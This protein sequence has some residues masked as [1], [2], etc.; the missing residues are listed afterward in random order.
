MNKFFQSWYL[1]FSASL[2]FFAASSAATTKNDH[3]FIPAEFN[4]QQLSNSG[5]YSKVEQR[6]TVQLDQRYH[7]ADSLF[8]ATK[9]GFKLNEDAVK[10]IH[11]DF[12]PTP[13]KYSKL[14]TAPIEKPWMDFQ[15][16]LSVPKSMI[17]TTK[18]R[19]PENYIRMLPYSIW[20]RFGIDPIYDMYVFGS[21]KQFEIM[22][23]LNLERAGE[24]SRELLPNAGK[25]NPN[26]T[27]AS[28]VI[29]NLDFIGFLYNNLNKQGR[30]R[31]HNRKHANAWKTY[32]SITPSSTLA[33]T[34]AMNGNKQRSYADNQSH[35]TPLRQY[36]SIELTEDQNPTYFS[37]PDHRL[38]QTPDQ[39]SRFGTF[40]D[41]ELY[42]MPSDFE[43]NDSIDSD[44]LYVT[45]PHLGL[46]EN[47]EEK[48]QTRSNRS[49]RRN[50]K[51]GSKH[52]KAT[53]QDTEILDELP[54]SMEDLYK[55]IRLRQLKDSLQRKEDARKDKVD[56]NV[57]ELEQQIR[58]L[59]ER[60]N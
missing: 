29:G 15:V 41:P 24:Y 43:K 58:K 18:V 31:K 59:R 21:K 4:I 27:G 32:Q 55:Y 28:V 45:K 33:E 37:R 2:T 19:K 42:A 44:S 53:Q 7:V 57:Y 12:S 50:P 34:G 46:K 13:Q 8:N 3:C 9:D 14:K 5:V 60:Q 16:D 11:F 56:Q 10:S 1:L 51:K 30:I 39:R 25:Y 36:K 26:S 35:E 54:N 17:D 23:K 47:N 52:N 38:L 48:R 40:Y 6:D 20:T 49:H 22:W